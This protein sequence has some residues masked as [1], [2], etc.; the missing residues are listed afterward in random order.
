MRSRGRDEG[1]AYEPPD[2]GYHDYANQDRPEG[3]RTYDDRD[4]SEGGSAWRP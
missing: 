2:N 1:R 3:G 4:R